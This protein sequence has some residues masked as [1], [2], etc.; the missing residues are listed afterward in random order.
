MSIF[1][2][3]Y[4]VTGFLMFVYKNH[5]NPISK[6]YEEMSVEYKKNNQSVPHHSSVVVAAFI[7]TIALWPATVVAF[8]M[9]EINKMRGVK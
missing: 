4:I 9:G 1:I 2:A 3:C 8:I 6:I 5:T 7:L